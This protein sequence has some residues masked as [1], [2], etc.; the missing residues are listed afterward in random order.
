VADATRDIK[1]ACEALKG[2]KTC[3]GSITTV[4]QKVSQKGKPVYMCHQYT[5]NEARYDWLIST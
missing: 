5:R 3:N 4:F 2:V 1:V